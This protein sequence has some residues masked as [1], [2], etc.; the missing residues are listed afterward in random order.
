ML[1]RRLRGRAVFPISSRR[2][3]D[4]D[5]GAEDGDGGQK[6][7]HLVIGVVR[8]GKSIDGRNLTHDIVSTRLV[9][10]HCRPS[11]ADNQISTNRQYAA[12]DTLLFFPIRPTNL[13]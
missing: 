7:E 13:P 5:A 2:S 6:E 9:S 4:A 1:Q 12:A 11:P 3:S 8:H 10:N